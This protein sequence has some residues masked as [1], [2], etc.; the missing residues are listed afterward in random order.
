MR[1]DCIGG[2]WGSVDDLASWS[3]AWHSSN[4]TA[5]RA[6]RDLVMRLGLCSHALLYKQ[7]R[8]E[9]DDLSDLLRAGLL[10]ASALFSAMLALAETPERIRNIVEDGTTGCD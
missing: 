6:A 4:S 9:D 1:K 2:L 5:D 7:A 3:A 8:S 10:T